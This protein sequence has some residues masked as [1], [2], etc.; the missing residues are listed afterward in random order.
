MRALVGLAVLLFALLVGPL[1]GPARARAQAPCRAGAPPEDEGWTD[2]GSGVRW[3]SGPE[4][5]RFF[6]GGR[7]CVAHTDLEGDPRPE[8]RQIAYATLLVL[9]W[10]YDHGGT[11]YY[12]GEG[13]EIWR[14]DGPPT[15]V[16][17]VIASYDEGVASMDDE[18]PEAT[19]CTIART[20]AIDES[21]VDLGPRASRGRCGPTIRRLDRRGRRP[22][23]A[24][25]VTLPWARLL[26]SSP[27]AGAA[28]TS[29]RGGTTR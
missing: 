1:H 25:A 4:G 22:L 10:S 24:G 14:V 2:L 6:V 8:L 9:H 21:G 28:T 7:T 29:A 19:T 15:F 12:G 18:E 16:L 27:A 3:A 13:Y 20:I 5:V 23:D 17:G 11:L 26:A